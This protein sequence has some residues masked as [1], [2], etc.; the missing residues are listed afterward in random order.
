MSP[1]ELLS[2]PRAACALA[3]AALMLAVL[4]CWSPAAR[5]ETF[6]CTAITSLPYI[7]NAPGHYC[8]NTN[9]TLSAPI[10]AAI[11]IRT[12]SVVLDC[13]GHTLFS[14]PTNTAAG[15]YATPNHADNIVR[16]CVI[17]G[18]YVGIFLQGT[19]DPGSRGNR[20]E[21]NV[22][23]RCRVTGI[24]IYGSHNVVA[25][26]RVTQCNANY[27]GVAKGIVLGSFD[28]NNAGNV[29]RDN[30]VADFKPTPPPEFFPATVSGI[31]FG[32]LRNTVITGNTISGLYG[33]TGSSVAA[34]SAFNA[35][36]TQ[37]SDNTILAP[38]PLA[39]PLDGT[40]NVGV[41]LPGTPEEQATNLCSDNVVGH[42]LT[43]FYGCV[44][45]T[46][47]GI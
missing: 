27:G 26:N 10:A 6:N 8:L 21:D 37:I 14:T 47:T 32:G 30:V 25:R 42:F 33:N 16:N 40:S 39:A 4:A 1:S 28:H 20:V 23:S 19:S 44:T 12:G 34:M 29:I 9:L 46:N 41:Y 35:S 31:E 43:S 38:P 2:A 11:E 17:D 36:G 24:L 5:A 15:V 3:F 7:I 18:Y 22:V 13:N 45:A